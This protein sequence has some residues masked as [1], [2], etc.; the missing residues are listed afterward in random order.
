[1]DNILDQDVSPEDTRATIVE[2]ITE[3]PATEITAEDLTVA[4]ESGIDWST[5]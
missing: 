5:L 2:Q 3:T 1:M 4:D